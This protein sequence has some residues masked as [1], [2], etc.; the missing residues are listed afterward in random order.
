MSRGIIVASLCL[1]AGCC[2]IVVD[3]CESLWLV[4]DRCGS[5]WIVVARSMFYLR[6]P[7]TLLHIFNVFKLSRTNHQWVILT[8]V[9]RLYIESEARRIQNNPLAQSRYIPCCN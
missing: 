7:R 4:V 6:K 2:W 5:L 1:L 3:R 9:F 8:Y